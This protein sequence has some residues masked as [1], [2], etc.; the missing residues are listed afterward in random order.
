MAS[1]REGNGWD[2]GSR[3]DAPPAE[4]ERPRR[5]RLPGWDEALDLMRTVLGDDA[6]SD[7]VDA[8]AV[9][10]GPPG[11]GSPTRGGPRRP[12]GASPR[13]PRD[14]EAED[15]LP[16][17]PRV[18][19]ALARYRVEVDFPWW[20]T[21]DRIKPLNGV[22]KG[23]LTYPKYGRTE[24]RPEVIFDVTRLYQAAGVTSTRLHSD[25]F[26]VANIFR[27]AGAFV[28]GIGFLDGAPNPPPND[29]GHF[30][31]IVESYLGAHEGRFYSRSG[32]NRALAEASVY[33]NQVPQEFV[34]I[35]RWEAWLYWYPATDSAVDDQGNYIF[36]SDTGALASY[37][38]LVDGGFEIYFRVGESN[39][40]PS[41]MS[42]SLGILHDPIP[43]WL[44]YAGAA[45]KILHHLIS[46]TYD[47]ATQTVTPPRFIEIWNE[48]NGAAYT[49][50]HAVAVDGVDS[51]PAGWAEDFGGMADLV[52]DAV[53]HFAPTAGFGF[54]DQGMVDFVR[55]IGGGPPEKV[56]ELLKN[57]RL[58]E[59]PFLSFH[60]YGM[61]IGDTGDSPVALMDR[62]M[63]FADKLV[64][65]RKAVNLLSLCQRLFPGRCTLE[66]LSYLEALDFPLDHS[67]APPLHITEWNAWTELAP[68]WDFPA[69]GLWGAFVSFGLTVMQH[70]DLDVE[71]AHFWDGRVARGPLGDAN[72]RDTGVGLFSA[73]QQLN[74]DVGFVVR[75][76]ALA[77]SL[78]AGIEEDAWIPVEIARTLPGIPESSTAMCSDVL[79]AAEARF[80]VTA[81][82]TQSEDLQRRTVIVTNLSELER[83]V[84][85]AV[86]GLAVAPGQ[87]HTGFTATIRTLDCGNFPANGVGIHPA[88]PL[89]D[90]AEPDLQE[91]EAVFDDHFEVDLHI[92]PANHLPAWAVV[93]E[94]PL[95][96]PGYGV[97]RIDIVPGGLEL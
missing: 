62:A 44:R 4:D 1:D 71:R 38:A 27:G 45:D 68:D 92:I 3:P 96:V 79:S 48:P 47:P 70:P 22:N 34:Q 54:S 49:G 23:V 17:S 19:P 43:L 59:L 91:V 10:M 88:D 28:S 77:M 90:P 20:V 9:E 32:L 30:D 37:A 29:Q 11:S 26:D 51:E 63:T 76:S 58:S 56:F 57:I 97:V 12:D 8:G 15:G 75:P 60:V 21:D 74:G 46:S 33:D 73:M 39:Q 14:P 69:L 64:D 53:G 84:V 6:L 82:A 5:E 52:F 55:S 81:L 65:L 61:E 24:G 95:T 66:S 31:E 18:A 42:P 83:E 2:G 93:G 80:E 89:T 36:G 40:G 67:G 86:S 72:P 7:F 25:V 87:P 78:H 50:P 85:V 94:I 35:E 16:P 13:E 41:Y